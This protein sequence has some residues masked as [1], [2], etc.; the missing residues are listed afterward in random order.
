MQVSSLQDFLN[1]QEQQDYDAAVILLDSGD[2]SHDLFWVNNRP[3]LWQFWEFSTFRDSD[4]CIY[5]LTLH[6]VWLFSLF[7]WFILLAA[8]VVSQKLHL[9]QI[10]CIC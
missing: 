1:H 9:K 2:S 8:T 7:I 4:I 6:S 3:M 10:K 5:K